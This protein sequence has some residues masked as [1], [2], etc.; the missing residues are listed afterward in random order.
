MITPLGDAH[1][2]IEVP[3][4]QKK[5]SGDPGAVRAAGYAGLG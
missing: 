5:S 4:I 3:D 2:E 1:E